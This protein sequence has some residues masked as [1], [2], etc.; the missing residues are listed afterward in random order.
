MRRKSMIKSIKDR[1]RGPTPIEVDLTGPKGNAYY[2]LSLADN[3]AKQLGYD[4]LKRERIQMEMMIADYECL[5]YT[6]N[7]EFGTLVTLWR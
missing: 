1:P 2:L 5:L 6:F 3:L 4:E 7:R